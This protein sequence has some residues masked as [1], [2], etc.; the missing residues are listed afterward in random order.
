MVIRHP[1]PDLIRRTLLKIFVIDRSFF[2]P[3]FLMRSF[4]VTTS[5]LLLFIASSHLIA[6][7]NVPP[8]EFN[9]VSAKSEQTTKLITNLIGR[10]HYRKPELNDELS[11]AIFEQYLQN[12][13]PNRSYFLASDIQQFENLRFRFDDLLKSVQLEPAYAIFSRYR[14]RALERI[15]YARELL[16][17]RFNFEIDEDYTINRENEQW[18]VIRKISM[19]YGANV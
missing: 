17:A 18:A 15:T 11:S 12:L 1:S 7:S 6:S 4:A 14:L 9:K 10:S 5:C 13:D 3:P 16:D 19:T 2:R 8:V